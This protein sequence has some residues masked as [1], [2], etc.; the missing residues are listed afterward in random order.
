MCCLGQCAQGPTLR[1][2][3]GGDFLFGVT[4]A[5]LPALLDEL[6]RRFGRHPEADE[7]EVLP[8]HLPGS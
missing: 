2:T 8:L 7:T 1:L 4:M 5:D 3:P 6:E